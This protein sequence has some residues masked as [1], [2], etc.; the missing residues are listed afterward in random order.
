MSILNLLNTGIYSK[1]S[2]GT[3]LTSLLSSSTAIYY[4]QAPDGASLPYVVFSHQA[5]G[6]E[7]IT[8]SDLRNQIV[9]VRG[10]AR[11]PTLVNSIDAAISDLLHRQALTIAGYTNFWTARESEINLVENEPNTGRVYIAGA[12]YRIR[13][14]A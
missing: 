3:A 12:L 5:G 6:P 7:N 13:V 8:S 14:D 10:V 2:G 9:Y 1:L 11:T 4:Q